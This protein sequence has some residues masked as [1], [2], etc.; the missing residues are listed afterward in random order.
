MQRSLCYDGFRTK[1]NNKP[2]SGNDHNQKRRKD[3]RAATMNM[4]MMNNVQMAA[5]EVKEVKSGL[6]AMAVAF[7]NFLFAEEEHKPLGLDLSPAMAARL[8]L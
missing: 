2:H 7:V 1:E 4:E 3:M 8:Y 5:Q 6:K